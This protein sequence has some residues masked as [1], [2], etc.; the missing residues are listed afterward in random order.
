MYRVS[1]RTVG[2]NSKWMLSEL[3]KNY[4]FNC[5][6]LIRND[7]FGMHGILLQIE[8]TLRILETWNL[9]PLHLMKS[10][11]SLIDNNLYYDQI[12]EQRFLNYGPRLPGTPRY[13]SPGPAA[14]LT[15][16]IR[17]YVTRVHYC[18]IVGFFSI[19]LIYNIS[20]YI[21]YKRYYIISSLLHHGEI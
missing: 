21:N 5:L 8:L 4:G 16:N 12:I 11:V 9:Y 20:Y 19:Y 3:N 13:S 10:S 15:H 1:K 6:K 18:S 2:S 7:H 14:A 17:Q